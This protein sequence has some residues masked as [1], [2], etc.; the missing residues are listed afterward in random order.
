MLA[1]VPAGVL[2]R[3]FSEKQVMLSGLG[4]VT[5]GMLMLY[6]APGVWMAIVFLFSFWHRAGAV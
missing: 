1:D 3:R 2:L 4:L 5:L 6:L